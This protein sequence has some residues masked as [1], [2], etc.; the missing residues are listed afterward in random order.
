ADADDSGTL[1]ITDAIR[2][3]LHLFAGGPAPPEPYPEAG[4]DLT[5]DGLT[6]GD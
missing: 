3:L 4:E 5:P 1:E 6:C 2:L